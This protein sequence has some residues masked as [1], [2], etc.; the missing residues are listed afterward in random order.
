MRV[1][2]DRLLELGLGSALAEAA[3]RSAT[4]SGVRSFMWVEMEH[5]LLWG[6][7][8]LARRSP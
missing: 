5:W 4:L 1:S 3:R 6:S 2:D 7:M 8:I